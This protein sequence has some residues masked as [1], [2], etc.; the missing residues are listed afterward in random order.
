[1]VLSQVGVLAPMTG[2]L[3]A[4]P[5]AALVLAATGADLVLT[6]MRGRAANHAARAAFD[7]PAGLQ[8]AS[9]LPLIVELYWSASDT[10]VRAGLDPYLCGLLSDVEADQMEFT[11][12]GVVRSMRRLAARPRGRGRVTPSVELQNAASGALGRLGIAE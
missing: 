1:M 8:S 4:A 2:L 10:S 6:I 5:V 9:D 12:A 3:M 11:A 7:E